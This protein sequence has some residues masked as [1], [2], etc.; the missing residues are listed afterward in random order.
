[1][2]K[3]ITILNIGY[4]SLAFAS[5]EVA[6]Q[7]FEI[8]TNVVSVTSNFGPL[9]DGREDISFIKE[10]TRELSLCNV[11]YSKVELHRTKVEL[12]KRADDRATREDFPTIPLID[13]S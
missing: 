13:L 2:A 6:L 8:L 4:I 11:E 10:T 1:M 5:V 3:Q 12:Q 9:P 7:A